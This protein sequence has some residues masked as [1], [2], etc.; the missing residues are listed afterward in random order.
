MSQNNFDASL[1]LVLQ[2]EGGYSA[3][4]CDPG[5]ITNLGVTQRVME[6]WLGHP[7]D[8]KF[9]QKLTPEI[10]AP[11]YK[12]KYWMACSA[13]KLPIGLDY[14]VFDTA[15]NMGVGT[16]VK[17]LQES[18]GCVPDAMLG[19]RTIQLIDQKDPTMMLAKFCQRR[20]DYY[21][22]FKLFPLYGKGW[23]KRVEFV[24]ENALKMIGEPK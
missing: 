7:V 16:A 18:L 1:K 6:E 21:S 8:D 4:S 12:A 23:L 20:R 15:V 5:G 10:V 19:P 17:L 24:F 13:P 2:S 3:E 14:A 9:M 11:L 22:G